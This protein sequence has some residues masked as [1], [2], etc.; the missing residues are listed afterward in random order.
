MPHS[1]TESCLA[2]IY[3]MVSDSSRN[4]A[5]ENGVYAVYFQ[6]TS[7]TSHLLFACLIDQLHEA[8]HLV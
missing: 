3:F 1:I 7:Q 6:I 4:K 8:F 2:N 5:E